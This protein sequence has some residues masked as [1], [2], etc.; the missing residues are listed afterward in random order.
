MG[1]CSVEDFKGERIVGW[2]TYWV[3]VSISGR[4]AGFGL[5]DLQDRGIAGWGN[6]KVRDLLGGG[7]DE[8]VTCWVGTCRGQD[9]KGEKIAGWGTFRVADLQGER[10]IHV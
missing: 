4:L 2:G 10:L 5:G 3:G 8:W 6:C 9:L 7:I 1:T